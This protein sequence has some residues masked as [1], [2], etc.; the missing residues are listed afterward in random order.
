VAASIVKN[1]ISKL[2]LMWYHSL[3]APIKAPT[4][5]AGAPLIPLTG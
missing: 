2:L 4:G 1:Y 5:L 3:A